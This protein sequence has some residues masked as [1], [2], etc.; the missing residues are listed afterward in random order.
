MSCIL[1]GIRRWIGR[2]GD[3]VLM[4]WCADV[5][6]KQPE[7][8]MCWCDDVMMCWC[9]DVMM[10]W[11]N[12]QCADVIMWWCVR[13]GGCWWNSWNGQCADVMMWWCADETAWTANEMMWWCV[14]RG[15]CWWNSLNSQCPD[16]L[17][18]LCVECRFE[19][20]VICNDFFLMKFNF[21]LS[22][23]II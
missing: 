9:D 11:W 15:G 1:N 19:V 21:Y 16:V 13:R 22:L 20:V 3:D 4:W 18:R 6:M 8:P 23:F 7:R 17:M 10:C 5:L 12:S 2:R 14:R